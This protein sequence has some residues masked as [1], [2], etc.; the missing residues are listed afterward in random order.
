MSRKIPDIDNNNGLPRYSASDNSN[1]RD[2]RSTSPPRDDSR[3]SRRD[4]GPSRLHGGRDQALGNS[5]VTPALNELMTEPSRPLEVPAFTNDLSH[6]DNDVVVISL[7]GVL[8]AEDIHSL[9]GSLRTSS[10]SSPQSRPARTRRRRRRR[11]TGTRKRSRKRARRSPS[12]VQSPGE[13][14]RDTIEVRSNDGKTWLIPCDQAATM[15][16]DSAM[17]R[18]LS[19]GDQRTRRLRSILIPVNAGPDEDHHQRRGR[20]VSRSPRSKRSSHRRGNKSKTGSPK[21]SKSKKKGTRSKSKKRH[22]KGKKAPK[23][24]SRKR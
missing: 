20:S 2:D 9:F 14:S 6:P 1:R 22:K 18:A 13:N 3:N 15:R 4:D 5:D 7:G 21:K 11:G 19:D 23:K 12:Q 24:R 10:P 16:T 8:T 17:G